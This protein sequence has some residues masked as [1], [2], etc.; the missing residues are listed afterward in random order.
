MKSPKTDFKFKNFKVE[1]DDEEGDVAMR[2]T[3]NKIG[4]L[5]D[6]P[7][8]ELL[9]RHINLDKN[10]ILMGALT[11]EIFNNPSI[12]AI[13]F[14]DPTSIVLYMPKNTTQGWHMSGGPHPMSYRSESGPRKLT[15]Y[16]Y[17]KFSKSFKH[18]DYDNKSKIIAQIKQLDRNWDAY[19]RRLSQIF[20]LT[21]KGDLEKR[22]KMFG[23]LPK[24]VKPKPEFAQKR[25]N[26]EDFLKK[27]EKMLIEF[28]Y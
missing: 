3:P 13:P 25:I 12:K 18:L 2:S 6:Y 7:I 26:F 14:I 5:K 28:F 27:R 10:D 4:Y 22:N 17:L 16:V 11:R 21:V 23:S 9:G 1:V 15:G 8:D 20:E 24:I 19:M